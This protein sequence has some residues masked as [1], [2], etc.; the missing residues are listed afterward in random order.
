MKKD[1][2]IRIKEDRRQ[3]TRLRSEFIVKCRVAEEKEAREIIATTRDISAMGIFFET[4]H[5]Y[6]LNTVLEIELNLPP[7]AKKTKAMVKVS[8]VEELLKKETYGIGATFLKL[9]GEDKEKIMQYIRRMDVAV[10]LQEAIKQGASDLHLSL[11]HPPC[12]RING[13]LRSIEAPPLE[14]DDLEIMVLNMMNERQRDVF[15]RELELDMSYH[16]PGVGRFR[17]NIHMQQGSIEAAIRVIPFKIKTIEEL[18]LPSAL[19]DLARKSNGMILVTGP[20]GCGKSTTLAAMI[21][22][23]NQEREA[24]IVSI[25]D[26]IEYIFDIKK[27]I[28]KQR[29]VNYDTLSF[30]NA[31]KHICRQNPDVIFIGELRD[32]ESI[33][34]AIAAAEAG[35]L[36]LST[37]HTI[38]TAHATNR[39]IE[40]FP[41][42]HQQQIRTLL[43]ECLEGIVAQN[44]LPRK[45][46]K[47]LVPAVEVLIATPAVR[48]I[49]K[50]GETA[51]LTSVIQ[52]SKKHQ[53]Q[54]MNSSVME[55]Y[56]KGLIDHETAQLNLVT[57]FNKEF[58]YEARDSKNKKFTGTTEALSRDIAVKQLQ[59]KDLIVIS[60]QEVK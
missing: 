41:P 52:L 2:K 47:G 54:T 5:H 35:F 37:L 32:L 16:I 28:I 39:L 36:V 1:V 13:V 40:V 53:M 43:S 24:V 9:D 22:L 4:K 17:V 14:Q 25:E 59:E 44:L 23:I 38:D 51:Q 7:L 49:I 26:P 21:E 56:E 50:S 57:P 46:R 15:E 12:L 8:R 31:L 6:P 55:L 29:E 18:G 48:N 60:I 45:D 58:F 20:S 33:A 27:S 30:N 3:F 10:L 34:T 19:K 11:N 42:E